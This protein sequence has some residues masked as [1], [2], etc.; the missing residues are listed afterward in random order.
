MI[1]GESASQCFQVH[2]SITVYVSYILCLKLISLAR[3]F[4]VYF[5]QPVPH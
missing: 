5:S 2:I 4:K 3:E 1:M